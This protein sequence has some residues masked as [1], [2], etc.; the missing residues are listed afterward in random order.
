MPDSF[1]KVYFELTVIKMF[2][3][4]KEEIARKIG[5]LV[6]YYNERCTLDIFHVF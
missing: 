3:V 4:I 2:N 5:S 6:K 1:R